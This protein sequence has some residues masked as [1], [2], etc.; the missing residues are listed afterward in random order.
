MAKVKKLSHKFPAINFV[1]DVKLAQ[2]KIILQSWQS[3]TEDIH[4]K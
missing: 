1:N 4:F 2:Q 3:Q